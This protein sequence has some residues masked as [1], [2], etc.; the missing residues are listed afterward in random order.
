MVCEAA[1]PVRQWLCFWRCNRCCKGQVCYQRS[2]ATGGTGR[3]FAMLC[4]S[5]ER[6]VLVIRGRDCVGCVSLSLVALALVVVLVLGRLGAQ[7]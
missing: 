6:A 2:G 1:L 3:A 5:A 4:G 7:W